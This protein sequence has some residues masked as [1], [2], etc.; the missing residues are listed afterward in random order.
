[1]SSTVSP[2]LASRKN[3]RDRAEG[4]AVEGAGAAAAAPL[5][6]VAGSRRHSNSPAQGMQQ[7]PKNTIRVVTPDN[8]RAEEGGH[9]A[10]ETQPGASDVPTLQASPRTRL[11]GEKSRERPRG[12][13]FQ[14]PDS[15]GSPRT[16]RSRERNSAP[17]VSLLSRPRTRTIHETSSQHSTSPSVSKGRN[18][19]SSVH[20][21]MSPSFHDM[22]TRPEVSNSI[23]IPSVTT[24]PPPQL[25]HKSNS[26]KGNRRLARKSSRPVSPPAPTFDVPSVDSLPSPTATN[27]VNKLLMLMKT[28]AGRMRGEVEQQTAGHRSWLSGV[29]YI[30]ETKGS[31]NYDGDDRGPFHLTLISDLRGC[32]VRA[33][34]L[35]EKSMRCLQI[36]G[37]QVEVMLCPILEDDFDLWL[38]ALL[39]W[40][41]VRNGPPA[42]GL[43]EPAIGSDSSSSD[44]SGSP[45]I[46]KVAK[47]LLWDKGPASSPSVVMRRPSTRN[48]A[49]PSRSSWRKVSCTLHDNGEFK[50]LS[51]NDVMLLSVIQ[52]WQLSRSAIQQLDKSVL[53]EKF[54]VG[55]FPQYAST[56][57]QLSIFRPV[58]LAFESRILFEVWF[59]LLRAF[60]IPEI[61]GPELELDNNPTEGATYPPSTDGMFRIEKSV[62]LRVVEARIRRSQV[63]SE[64]SG[65]HSSKQE[66]ESTVGDYFVEAILDGEVRA[67]TI[68][69]TNTQYPFWREDYEF[70][71]LPASL[72]VLT[73]VLKRPSSPE[74]LTHKLLA[75]SGAHAGE[76]SGDII[77]GTLDIPLDSLEKGKDH[78]EWFPILDD[79]KEPAGSLF[80]KL[81]VDEVAVL[82]AQDYK[83]ISDMLHRFN[84]G[85]TVRISQVMPTNLRR[86]SEILINI[87]QVSGQAG[88]WLISLVEEEI[89]GITKEIPVNRIRW[90]RRVSSNEAAVSER[91]L[92]V[93]DMGKSLQGEANLLFRG[94]SLLTQALDFHMRRLG[95]EYLEEVLCEKILEI[96]SLNADCE[97]DPS[98]IAQGA[99]INKN[100]TRLMSF[101]TE[102]WE[103]IAESVAG[104]PPE[105]R[106]ILK[107]VRAV[108]EDRYGDFLR[109]VTYTSVSGFLFLR[110]FCPALLNPK[111]F[112]LLP[113]SPQPKAQR[114]LTLIAKSLQALANLSTF[115]QKEEWMAPMNKFLIGHRQALKC[116]IDDI[117]SIPSLGSQNFALS[118]SYSTPITVLARLPSPAKE[119]FPSLPYL[120]DHA[121][122]FA[123]LV[124]L[125]LDATASQAA[126]P[127]TQ[128]DLLYFH[129]LCLDLQRRT[130]ECLRQA[131]GDRHLDEPPAEPES[132]AK[133]IESIV[134]ED[135]SSTVPETHSPTQAEQPS[136]AQ[137]SA[138]SSSG[139]HVVAN[140]EK[141]ETQGPAQVSQGKENK[142]RKQNDTTADTSQSSS[143]GKGP[144]RSV[145]QSRTLFGGLKRK[146]KGDGSGVLVKDR[147]SSTRS[148]GS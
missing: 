37:E 72:P 36:T 140:G 127:G 73:L 70:L 40:Q 103:S 78:E 131:E 41:E 44:A 65:N 104:C 118:A 147:G 130:H 101:T 5:G 92:S 134:I 19:I 143:S 87:F 69:R 55:I 89:D 15:T 52:L 71:H 33:V 57:T 46:I 137:I 94:N 116:F 108:A 53:G 77:C 29:C 30:D 28:F 56:S 83:D 47:L 6:T 148:S 84:T 74:A 35:E 88:E 31:L 61:Y 51:E 18:R 90:T 75:S 8:P 100:W 49:A 17:P 79:K 97:V 128:D 58:Y 62:N 76:K 59:S 50:L 119:G 142:P 66:P 125:W 126:P 24:P 9:P 63:A 107:Y 106:Q 96:N 114:T 86:L 42:T 123:A 145:K 138:P 60:S 68:T 146:G 105:M 20:A 4:V 54:C 80:L 82:L 32:R 115:G 85:L 25:L 117:C 22:E 93:R 12:M 121:R 98:R 11:S 27:D 26:T 91:E 34:Q 81:R 99:D 67:R 39:C 48:P 13:V 111:L 7:K 45:N 141:R 3:S 112:G 113:D 133:D 144:S 16:S 120:I 136:L 124:T 1:M 135:A 23:G 122:N 102:I 109:T 64:A 14:D 38:A 21:A 10:A 43:S 95:S 139:S 2:G 110:F 132:V 129:Q